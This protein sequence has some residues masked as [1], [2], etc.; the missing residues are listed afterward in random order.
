MPL[1][2]PV[3]FGISPEIN[4]EL[5]RGT[6]QTDFNSTPTRSLANRPTGSSSIDMRQM[7]YGLYTP[8]EGVGLYGDRFASFSRSRATF[9]INCVVVTR[10]TLNS[11]GTGNYRTEATAQNLN[12][13]GGAIDIRNFTWKQPAG[14]VG[15]YWVQV[16]NVVE[17]SRVVT[18]GASRSVVIDG[19]AYNTDVRLSGQ[20]TFAIT[21]T[22]ISIGTITIT[23]TADII[24]K[25]STDGGPNREEFFRRPISS[26]IYA[27]RDTRK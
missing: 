23:H 21:V 15:D 17:T 20:A 14:A 4:T 18:G 11:N 2:Q 16:G 22:Q 26:Y 5:A 7:Y 12:P 1:P 24:M 13:G 3:I 6:T 9:D 19:N 27:E 8:S 10:V 25:Y